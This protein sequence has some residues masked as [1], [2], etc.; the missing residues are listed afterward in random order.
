MDAPL[1][2][3]RGRGVASAAAAPSAEPRAHV[4]TGSALSAL[5]PSAAA[6]AA[7]PARWSADGADDVCAV[8]RRA[9]APAALT[10]SEPA[11]HA[12]NDLARRGF[13]PAAAAP[14]MAAPPASACAR[15]P[16]LWPQRSDAHMTVWLSVVGGA[17][18]WHGARADVAN[19]ASELGSRAPPA[20][21]SAPTVA[22]APA[23]R[24]RAT[25]RRPA[26][27]GAR[28]ARRACVTCVALAICAAV[29]LVGMLR[30]ACTDVRVLAITIDDELCE[31]REAISSQ[32]AGAA[33][34]RRRLGGASAAGRRR[35]AAQ[36]AR[37]GAGV[38]ADGWAAGQLRTPPPSPLARGVPAAPPPPPPAASV[39]SDGG[40]VRSDGGSVR[41]DGG[42]SVGSAPTAT[43]AAPPQPAAKLA[44]ETVGTIADEA[45]VGPTVGITVGIT[46]DLEITVRAW[47]PLR[48]RS[49]ALALAAAER[50]GAAAGAPD[51]EL[52]PPGGG[53][54]FVDRARSLA[55]VGAPLVEIAVV[56]AKLLPRHAAA[57][58]A[59]TSAAATATVAAAAA[60]A[61]AATH[62]APACRAGV[63]GGGCERA[64]AAERH[65]ER[66]AER[67]RGAHVAAAAAAAAAAATVAASTAVAAPEPRASSP[68]P[69]PAPP[70]PPPPRARAPPPEPPQTPQ[71]QQPP[72]RGIE[73]A[74]LATLLP[75]THVYRVRLALVVRNSTA[76]RS[77]AHGAAADALARVAARARALAAGDGGGGSNLRAALGGAI[78]RAFARAAVAYELVVVVGGATVD[79]SERS[80]GDRPERA[81]DG[82]ERGAGDDP[83]ERSAG[84]R[85]ERSVAWRWQLPSWRVAVR[86]KVALSSDGLAAVRARRR[87]IKACLFCPLPA[88]RAAHTPLPAPPS[89]AQ[90]GA[91]A[92]ALSMQ[93]GSVGMRGAVG[94]ASGTLALALAPSRVRYALRL[95]PIALQ[96]CALR[97]APQLGA[98]PSA[99]RAR[100]N[101]EGASASA[102][103]QP[104]GGCAGTLS[105]SSLELHGG[106]RNEGLG[107]ARDAAGGQRAGGDDDGRPSAAG[108]PGTARAAGNATRGSRARSRAAEYAGGELRVGWQLL[109]PLAELGIASMLADGGAS[110]GAAS[111]G[112][113]G[114]AAV[115][116]GGAARGGEA[117]S[118][119]RRVANGTAADKRAP[120]PREK[121]NENGLVAFADS[122]QNG[123]ELILRGSTAAELSALGDSA[124]PPLVVDSRCALQSLL[125]RAP[126]AFDVA[127]TL[128]SAGRYVQHGA[129]AVHCA[130]GLVRHYARGAAD[131]TGASSPPP[132]SSSSSSS[133]SSSTTTTTT[134]EGDGEGVMAQCVQLVRGVLTTINGGS[135]GAGAEP[136]PRLGT[137]QS[138]T[139]YWFLNADGAS[140]TGEGACVSDTAAPPARAGTFVERR[141]WSLDECEARCLAMSACVALS[142]SEALGRCELWRVAPP[143]RA[144]GAPGHRCVLLVSSAQLAA[145]RL[146]AAELAA[147]TARRFAPPALPR[148]YYRSKPLLA[149]SL[150]ACAGRC[151]AEGGAAAA[152]RGAA[153]AAATGGGG[154]GGGGGGA[155]RGVGDAAADG[156]AGAGAGADAD[157]DDGCVTI[158]YDGMGGEC[159]LWR[160]GRAAPFDASAHAGGAAGER[161][162]R[163]LRPFP[164]PPPAPPPAPPSPPAP[165]PSPPA[166]ANEVDLA[167]GRA[168]TEAPERAGRASTTGLAVDGRP[169]S[170]WVSAP[171]E[172]AA[173]IVEF[174]AVS[175]V[176]RVELEWGPG[177][178][179]RYAVDVRL[180]SDGGWD[181]I[182]RHASH[183]PGDR[184]VH[185]MRSARAGRGAAVLAS[186]VRLRGMSTGSRKEYTVRTFAVFGC[187]VDTQPPA[188]PPRPHPP[189]TPPPA[190]SP[191]PS[192]PSPGAPAAPPPA[193]PSPPCAAGCSPT[194]C[195]AL[196]YRTQIVYR[197]ITPISR[198]PYLHGLQ[199][200]ALALPGAR[201]AGGMQTEACSATWYECEPLDGRADG[202]GRA[203]GGGTADGGGMAGGGGTGAGAGAEAAWWSP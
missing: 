67:A 63:D 14:A 156:G 142:H 196:G 98:Q 8:P 177:V 51:A 100:A 182:V 175:R 181:E 53:A 159:A 72:E 167:Q 164:P 94:A 56:S 11:A 25:R 23:P 186:A 201:R 34:G 191:R 112:A 115:G 44:P 83:S 52:E 4:G 153:A 10:P 24:E 39:R 61:A 80:A 20:T 95:P 35:D 5:D 1:N 69:P 18:P 68:P 31:P 166:C 85:P 130:T 92:R 64:A 32:V 109:L 88:P 160:V 21:E 40:S 46:V 179:M 60:A 33:R 50:G 117:R 107:D 123:G 136:T 152:A 116:A 146:P 110:G 173:L 121:G 163:L 37:S 184:D 147:R 76:A 9:R 118:A 171:A 162:A 108:A 200:C 45:A 120:A 17:E 49:V 203:G 178:R 104:E 141:V 144:D 15:P 65:A 12:R 168:A 140:R 128:G 113:G 197:G 36:P 30:A 122:I 129:Q 55:A 79:L 131:G 143:A 137:R 174:G 149:S 172:D 138:G 170:A 13:A 57:A 82:P 87:R 132:P 66:E 157:V 193:P 180:G 96:L 19:S 26:F 150:G 29:P 89:A 111:G 188:S 103:A 81:G 185:D 43:A 194:P 176:V 154:G 41:S 199:P 48:I 202:G 2:A 192:P 134:E 58:A 38:G 158:E 151:A 3:A 161:V 119:A 27:G 93:L 16:A 91:S 47:W 84:D 75:G 169:D 105:I 78:R 183:A 99:A 165:P 135:R 90:R 114:G 42:S 126:L 101:G 127:T 77:F 62:G 198:C 124:E 59:G 97:A 28:A 74:L 195:C 22:F 102:P 125:M 187:E 106:G 71:P 155:P 86:R 148:P 189:P 73:R 54:R 145:L 139:L 190:P 7:R 133:S 70:A 6:T